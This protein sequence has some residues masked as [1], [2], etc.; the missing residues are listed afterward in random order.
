MSNFLAVATV[1]AA[2]RLIMLQ[3]IPKDVNGADVTHVRPAEGLNV[4][5][6]ANNLGV[7]IFLYQAQR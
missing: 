2:L 3:V 7:N 1:T 6:P 5:L 4:G